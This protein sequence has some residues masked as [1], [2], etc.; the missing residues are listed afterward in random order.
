[1]LAYVYHALEHFQSVFSRQ[2][3]WLKFCAIIIGFMSATEM[4]GVTSLCRF[5]LSSER[6]YNNLL[7]FFS[8]QGILLRHAINRLA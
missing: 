8:I 6:V 5:W 1:M 2:R 4:I 7:H 3:T